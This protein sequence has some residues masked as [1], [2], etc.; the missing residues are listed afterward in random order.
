MPSLIPLTFEHE[1]FALASK[2]ETSTFSRREALALLAAQITLSLGACSQPGEEILPYVRMPENIVP[3][4]PLRFATTLPLSGYGRGVVCISID[5][6]PIKIEGNALHPASLGSTDAFAEASIFGL[7]DPDRSK[8]TRQ[9]GSI[10]SW[11]MF[12]KALLPRVEHYRASGGKGLRLLTG[13]ISSP[14]L[15]R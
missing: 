9:H 14:T 13:R 5:G 11:D 4:E 6:R 12:L 8:T 1:T 7:Y 15:L 10:A 3:G 2:S